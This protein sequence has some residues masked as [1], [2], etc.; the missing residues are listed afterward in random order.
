M[1]R[2]LLRRWR[3]SGGGCTAR[4]AAQER[5]CCAGAARSR[6]LC[7]R[8]PGPRVLGDGGARPA[9]CTTRGMARA[10]LSARTWLA[11]AASL[12][13]AATAAAGSG[14]GGRGRAA[15]DGASI[16]QPAARDARSA[17]SGGD[18][19]DGDG[20]AALV[21]ARCAPFAV[22]SGERPGS[23]HAWRQ[24]LSLAACVQDGSVEAVDE[25]GALAAMVEELSGRLALPM[26]IYLGALEHGD[27]P[28]Q[29]RA[30]FQVGMAYVALSTRARSGIAALP[31]PAAATDDAARRH[32][33]LHARVELLLVPARRAAWVAFRAI[34]AAVEEDGVL[35]RD[36]VE[37][38]MVRA[39]RQML[40]ALR[41][42]APEGRTLLVQHPAG[43]GAPVTASVTAA[44]R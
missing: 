3:S 10:S 24:L 16:S 32:H 33:Q 4:I 39:A 41:D 8:A 42:A 40:P 15:A 26:K 25:L 13:P 27:A 2:A 29:L 9:G 37:R 12:L 20:L 17:R 23:E 38:Y 21:P 44:A 18:G 1:T 7:A 19:R 43:P 22:G 6:T 28:I 5:W 14:E 31:D 34:D 30:A 11:V 35:A 36:E